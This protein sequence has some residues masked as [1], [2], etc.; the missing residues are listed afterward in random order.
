MAK[1]I[2]SIRRKL[3]QKLIINQAYPFMES[4]VLPMHAFE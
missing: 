4:T 1:E 2:R 3:I